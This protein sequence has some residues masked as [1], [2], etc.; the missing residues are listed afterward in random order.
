MSNA[1]YGTAG[2]TGLGYKSSPHG[3]NRECQYFSKSEPC[4]TYY[5]GMQGAA[6]VCASYGS[7]YVCTGSR[8]T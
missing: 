5:A 3:G 8:Q 2:H 1:S 7:P 4:T 6:A